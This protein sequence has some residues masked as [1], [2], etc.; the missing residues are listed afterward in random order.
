MPC[1][2]WLALDPDNERVTQL[3]AGLGQVQEQVRETVGELIDSGALSEPSEEL[4]GPTQVVVV[5]N[6]FVYN[7]VR[8]IAGTLVEIGRGRFEP[9]QIDKVLETGDRRAAGLTLPARGLSPG[10]ARALHSVWIPDTRV[11]AA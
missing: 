9:D 8:I 5:G 10:R 11:D 2:V 7:M 1:G 4:V 3:L 6:G